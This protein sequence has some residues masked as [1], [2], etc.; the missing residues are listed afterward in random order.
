[1]FNKLLVA[2]RGENV[3]IADVSSHCMARAACAGDFTAGVTR[4]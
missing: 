1:M 2:N 3:R 4:V